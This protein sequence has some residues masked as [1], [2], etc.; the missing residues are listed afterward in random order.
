MCIYTRYV[1][2]GSKMV[3]LDENEGARAEACT[4]EAN[5]VCIHVHN[6]YMYVYVYVYVYM[7]MDVYMY[8]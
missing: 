7:Y 4:F 3:F 6:I 8:T 2:D 5:E 1:I